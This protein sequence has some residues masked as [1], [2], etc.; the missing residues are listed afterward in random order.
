MPCLQNQDLQ[1]K[2]EEIVTELKTLQL[3]DEQ[4]KDQLKEYK[5][6]LAE[7]NAECES[8]TLR[9]NYL[10]EA[11]GFADGRGASAAGFRGE[12]PPEGSGKPQLQSSRTLLVETRFG[13]LEERNRQLEEELANMKAELL[14][15]RE[16][17]EEQEVNETRAD[18]IAR[19]EELFN[20]IQVENKT[21][22]KEL[23]DINAK[24]AS[25]QR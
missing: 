1:K 7:K 15:L 24:L 13:E 8:M 18:Y 25:Q 5:K 9:I 2:I 3:Q 21:L 12:E 16:R 10:Q 22:K 19:I 11:Y 23:V 14:R 4:T 17:Q 6:R 20:S